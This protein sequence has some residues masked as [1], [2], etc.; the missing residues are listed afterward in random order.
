MALIPINEQSPGQRERERECEKIVKVQ[1]G[2][3]LDIPTALTA[4]VTLL[5][6]FLIFFYPRETA[7]E[8]PYNMKVKPDVLTA[9]LTILLIGLLINKA[10]V[11]FMEYERGVVFKLGKFNRIAGPG[12]EVIFPLFERYV[13]VDLRLEVIGLPTQEVVTKDKVRFLVAPEIFMYVSNPK[14]AVLN[15]QNYKKSVINYVNSAVTH[16]L[17]DSTSDYIVAHMNEISDML[18]H[19]V[20]HMANT[21]GK[22]WGV[23]IPRVKLSFIR[24]PDEVQSAM[25]KKVASEQLK[26]AAHEKAEATR[27][28][29]DAIREAGGKLTDPAITY[30][31]LEALDKM[32][33]GK[34]TKIVLPLEITKIAETMT[35]RTAGLQSV[36]GK[37]VGGTALSPEL[38]QRYTQAVDNYDKRLAQIENKI[39]GREKEEAKKIEDK[40]AKQETG[41][42]NNGELRDY[43]ERIKEIKRRVGIK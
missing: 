32:S 15:V 43:K 19:A 29:I 6:I 5:I 18:T 13:K 17:G 26:L 2:F 3:A 8:F 33:K 39:E 7:V 28:E 21:P 1:G 4:I 25:H 10:I 40:T 23:V 27:I 9:G 12:W 14:D 20:E 11:N 37:E 31:Y 30:M 16:T 24:F 42:E 34:A 22:E 38:M 36:S 41:E 35:K